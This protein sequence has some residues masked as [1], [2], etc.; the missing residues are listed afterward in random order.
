M[1]KA[2]L[3]LLLDTFPTQGQI[4]RTRQIGASFT[5]RKTFQI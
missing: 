2:V 4:L 5:F 1:L 3:H